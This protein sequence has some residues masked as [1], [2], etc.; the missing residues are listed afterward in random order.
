MTSHG[1][2]AAAL[3]LVMAS[4]AA[5]QIRVSHISL[6]VTGASSLAYDVP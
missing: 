2:T 3:A 4:G 6:Q 1:Y 5:A